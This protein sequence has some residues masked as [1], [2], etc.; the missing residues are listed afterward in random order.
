MPLDAPRRRRLPG[1]GR[2]PAGTRPSSRPSATRLAERARRRAGDDRGQGPQRPRDRRPLQRA[3]WSVSSPMR[4][5]GASERS[6]ARG[7]AAIRCRH[8]DRDRRPRRGRQVHRRARRR[9][10]ARLHLPRLRGDVP[11]RGAG[12]AAS[13]ASTSTTARR[14]A[15]WPRALEIDLDGERVALDGARRQR[16]DPRRPRSPPPPRGSRSTRGCA[17]R[18]SRASARLIAAGRY[19]AEGRDIGTVVSPDSPL[20]V[21]LTASDEERA[22][23]RAAETGEDAAA[24]LAAQRERDARDTEPRAQRPARRRRRGRDRHHRPLAGRGRRPRRRPRPRAGPAHEPAADRRRRRLPQRRQ[25]HPGQPARR[26]PRGGHPRRAG[27]H[28]RPQAA[29]RLRVE[30]RRLR[31]ARHRRHRPRRRGRAGRATSSAR[32]GSAI[33]EADVDPAR[34]RRAAP[35]SAPAT[36]SWRRRCAAPR[37]PVLVV[38][39]KVDRPERRAPDRRAPHARPRR[40]ARRSPPPTAS[41]PATCS[42]AI[43]AAARR[44]RA[45]GRA[46]TT[47]TRVAV[48]GRPNVGKSSLVNAFLGSERVIVSERAGTTRDAID[49]ELE[50][51]GRPRR[52]RRHRRPAAPLQ[53][54]RHRRLLRAAALRARGRARRRRDR[55]LRR[56][57]GRHRRGPAGRRAGDEGR[58]RDAAR[59]STSGTSPRTDIDDARA[60]VAQQAAPAAR[61]SITCSATRGRN[62]ANL[63]PKALEL[64]DR[65]AERIPTPELNRFV[66]DVVAKTPPPSR[67]G[68]RLRLYYA[69]QVGERPPRIAIQVN[70]R[71]LI[72]RDWAYHLENRHARDLRAR[73]RAAG[74]RLRPRTPAAAD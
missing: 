43:V 27:R 8:G 23:R 62:V 20:K 45:A 22:R 52:P 39:N 18:W 73:G 66:A 2:S 69:A 63:L 58:L 70:D 9:R 71:R 48:I 59:R 21:F 7:S 46:R 25:E 28:P 50:V 65:A 44:P 14:W 4:R 53:G 13:A 24:V 31:A 61:R 34:R 32:R 19:V 12:G 68:R 64:A 5:C 47:P 30:R 29:S 40:A 16:G 57:R 41:A 15:S 49:T 10:R 6:D 72:T 67:R 36:P 74:D 37:C 51:D 26:R 38:A 35:A 17:R 33:A 3:A 54:R 56:L 11:L 42:T 60:R 1:A 55:R